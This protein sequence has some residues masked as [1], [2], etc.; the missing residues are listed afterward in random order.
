MKHEP[1]VIFATD[2]G[3]KLGR[4]DTLGDVAV[5]P[6]AA[7]GQIAE[8]LVALIGPSSDPVTLAIPTSWCLSATVSLEG[9]PQRGRRAALLYRLE[10][11]V[12]LAA[13]EMTVDFI[14]DEPKT[15]LAVCVPIATVKPYT[16][17]LDAAG[18]GVGAIVPASL[19]AVQWLL[20][21]G[22]TDGPDA[23][24]WQS[25][26]TAELFVL[27]GGRVVGWYAL[28][29]DGDDLRLHLEP[30]T[31]GRSSPLRVALLIKDQKV[32][33]G[34]RSVSSI[35][36][37]PLEHRPVEQAVMAAVRDGMT[38]AIDLRRDGLSPENRHGRFG[39]INRELIAAAV[40]LVICLGA[41]AFLRGVRLQRAAA[42]DR[43]RQAAVF[44]EAFPGRPVPANI[45]T[46]LRSEERALLAG[47][48]PGGDRPALPSV[49]PTLHSVLAGF[50]SLGPETRIELQDLRLE[51]NQFALDGLARN[52]GDVAQLAD[53]LDHAGHLRTTPAQTEQAGGAGGPG[54]TA[55]AGIHFLLTGTRGE[56][57]K[58][59]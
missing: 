43:D 55:G 21:P 40:L 8:T 16:D 17:C 57:S 15:A 3:W 25:Q 29:V 13:E 54:A 14:F 59:Q 6:A 48:A 22:K 33:D 4:G 31:A 27:R 53:A 5:P 49:M 44:A 37:Q 41:A 2:A 23:V 12:P 39:K 34:L 42:A 24:V 46:R 47:T 52:R 32:T 20:R 11:L 10:L 28:P 35:A 38:P 45:L 58:P 19:L 30:L 18:V 56:E 7:P 51:D 26:S 1:A 50:S 9:V 36:L